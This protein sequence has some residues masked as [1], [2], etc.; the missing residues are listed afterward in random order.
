MA[1]KSLLYSTILTAAVCFAVPEANITDAAFQYYSITGTHGGVVAKTGWRP[2]RRNLLD[3]QKD[4]PTWYVLSSFVEQTLIFYQVLIH[5]STF[6]YAKR[7][8]K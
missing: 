6:C 8:S 1:S 4:A 3:M 2:A 7:Q 5:P